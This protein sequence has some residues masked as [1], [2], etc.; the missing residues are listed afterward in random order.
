MVKGIYDEVFVRSTGDC[1]YWRYV[2][3]DRRS[4]CDEAQ[5]RTDGQVRLTGDPS[6]RENAVRRHQYTHSEGYGKRPEHYTLIVCSAVEEV[7]EEP[8]HNDPE[9]RRR[10]LRHLSSITY[11]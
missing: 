3:P 9:H 8:S 6:Q 1:G 11:A 5:C 4:D 7:G 10:E 2:Q